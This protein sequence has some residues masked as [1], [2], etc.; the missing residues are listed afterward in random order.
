MLIT[1]STTTGEIAGAFSA[2]YLVKFTY[3]INGT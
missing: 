2:G 1:V 3:F